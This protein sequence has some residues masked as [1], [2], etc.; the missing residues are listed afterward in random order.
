MLLAC[1]DYEPF[2]TTE[3]LSP[4]RALTAST[5]MSI[6]TNDSAGGAVKVECIAAD[7]D[8]DADDVDRM[9][10]GV[11]FR[12]A[13]M[14]F[15]KFERDSV[16]RQL[17]HVGVRSG[18]AGGDSFVSGVGHDPGRTQVPAAARDRGNGGGHQKILE[19]SPHL[20]DETSYDNGPDAV[21]DRT[22]AKRSAPPT[23]VPSDSAR[24]ISFTPRTVRHPVAVM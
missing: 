5:S 1:N 9:R 11:A 2:P 6:E 14:T 7:R 18:L 23:A 19:H 15:V 3:N 17:V 22:G 20:E 13:Q 4:Y 16:R 12:I 21:L 10:S 8:I 24:S